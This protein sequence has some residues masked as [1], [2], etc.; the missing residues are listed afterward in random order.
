MPAHDFTERDPRPE[1]VQHRTLAEA[2]SGAS[3]ADPALPRGD[4][5]PLGRRPKGLKGSQGV[6]LVRSEL[7]NRI[8]KNQKL[9]LMRAGLTPSDPFNPF[10]PFGKGDRAGGQ[11]RNEACRSRRH[12]HQRRRGRRRQVRRAEF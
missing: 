1:I 9:N 7:V 8:L 11:E 5:G 6:I 12:G 4:F 2:G 10:N 3:I